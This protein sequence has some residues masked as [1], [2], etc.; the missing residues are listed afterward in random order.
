MRLPLRYLPDAA[1]ELLHETAYYSKARNGYG[2]RFKDAV[3]DAADRAAR[4]PEAGVP[5]LAGTRKV[6][7]EGFPFNLID[8]HG[9]NEILVVAIAPDR[10]RPGYWLSHLR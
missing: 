6:R 4:S 7:V 8:R 2:V 5:W 1:A 3:K 9:V 10:K